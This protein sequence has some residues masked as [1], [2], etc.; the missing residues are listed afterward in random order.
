MCKHIFPNQYAT[1]K[2][3]RGFLT[4]TL[5]FPLA[6]SAAADTQAAPQP[7]PTHC[8]GLQGNTD[9]RSSQCCP[10]SRKLLG[11][12]FFVVW[13]QDGRFNLSTSGGGWL[14]PTDSAFFSLVGQVCE[15]GL[16]PTYNINI[17]ERFVECRHDLCP[18]DLP[19]I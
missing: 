13:H 3:F 18:I 17:F 9:T 19:P 11:A 16:A 1:Q 7:I 6:R 5:P 15:Q 4:L 10:I 12:L 14:V 2:S 8:N